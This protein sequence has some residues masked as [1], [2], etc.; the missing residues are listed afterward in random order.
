M[1]LFNNLYLVNYLNQLI[2]RNKKS[3][4]K[5]FMASSFQLIQ[6]IENPWLKNN[7]SNIRVGDLLKISLIIQEGNKERVQFAEGIVI[8][9]NNARLNTTITIRKVIQGIGVE[10]T[11]LIHSPKISNIKIIKKSKVRRA[12]LYYLRSRYGKASR[13]KQKLK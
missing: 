1:I 2:I 5:F 3:T 11:Y 12:K 8:S 4:Y 9:K 13:L 6:E 10:R 7:F